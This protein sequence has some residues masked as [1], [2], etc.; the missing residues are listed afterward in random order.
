MPC[1]GAVCFNNV[2]A[3]ATERDKEAVA[4][5]NRDRTRSKGYVVPALKLTLDPLDA[6]M[7]LQ[8]EVMPA[9]APLASRLGVS[10]SFLPCRV[11]H[12]EYKY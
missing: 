2:G 11:N 6:G 3:G 1:A 4:I 5:D 7:Y 9:S 12:F 10:N 8:T